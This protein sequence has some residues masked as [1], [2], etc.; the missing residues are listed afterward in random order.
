MKAP[1]SWPKS[2]D[3]SSVSGRAAQFTA[4]KG[5]AARAEASWIA[6]RDEL[7]AGAASRR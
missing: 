1:R 2:S 4:T 5:A 3:S 7:L 6:P